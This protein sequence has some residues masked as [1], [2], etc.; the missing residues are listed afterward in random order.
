ME[1]AETGKVVNGN[2][3]AQT[4]FQ[5]YWSFSRDPHRGWV[6]DEIQQG[7]EGDYHMRTRD[8]DTDDG[9]SQPAARA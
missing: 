8:I 7:E 9:P 6:L 1:D 5:Q 3:N 2:P 4:T